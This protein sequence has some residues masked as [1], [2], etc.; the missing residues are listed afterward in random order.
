MVECLQDLDHQSSTQM[1]AE[2][3]NQDQ[4]MIQDQ[5]HD[6]DYFLKIVHGY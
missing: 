5:Q 6:L 1:N 3:K 4:K 2:H